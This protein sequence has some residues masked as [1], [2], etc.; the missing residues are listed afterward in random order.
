MKRAIALGTGL[1]TAS[2]LGTGWTIARRLTAP[3]GPRI[4]DLTI[5]DI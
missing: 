5:R 1:L 2:A 3:V 4:F